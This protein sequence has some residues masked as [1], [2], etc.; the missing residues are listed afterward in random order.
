MVPD[1]DCFITFIPLE[2]GCGNISLSAAYLI[3]IYNVDPHKISLNPSSAVSNGIH[4][5]I[6]PILS[7]S[8]EF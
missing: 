7:Q 6:V 1:T 2:T 5:P 4:S 8:S 3:K